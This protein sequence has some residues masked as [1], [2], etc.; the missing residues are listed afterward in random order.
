MPATSSSC[1]ADGE[2]VIGKAIGLD[3]IKEAVGQGKGLGILP[4]V[5]ISDW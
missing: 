2:E 3:C 1:A 5:R 4:V